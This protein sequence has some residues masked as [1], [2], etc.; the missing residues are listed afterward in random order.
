MLHVKSTK[1]ICSY[2][3]ILNINMFIIKSIIGVLLKMKE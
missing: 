3:G 2:K 1:L